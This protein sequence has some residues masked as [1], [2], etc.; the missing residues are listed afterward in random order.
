VPASQDRWWPNRALALAVLAACFFAVS[1]V[2][3][4]GG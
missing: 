1:W 3:R 2:A 4:Q